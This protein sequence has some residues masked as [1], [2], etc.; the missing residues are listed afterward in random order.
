MTAAAPALDADLVAGLKRLKLATSGPSPPR[1]SRRPRPSAGRPKSVLRALVEAEIAARDDSNARTR[2]HAAGFP[3]A[4]T[5]EEFNVGAVVGPP[6]DLRLPGVPGVAPGGGEPLPGR[7]RRHRQEPPP[8]RPR[9]RRRLRRLQGPLLH[10]RRSGR[11]A[12]PRPGRQHRRPGHRRPAARRP[13]DRR[14]ARLRAARRIGTQLLFRFVAAAYERRSLGIAS[15]WPFDQWGRF[16]PEQTTAASLLDRLLHHAVI[17][18]TEG[19]SYRMRE[20][21]TEGRP[22]LDQG[23]MSHEPGGDF[24][25]PPAGT[26]RWPLTGTYPCR[27]QRRQKGANPR[28]RGPWR[29][30]GGMPESPVKRGMSPGCRERVRRSLVPA[31]SLRQPRL[32]D[33]A[34]SDLRAEREEAGRSA[35][36]PTSR[37]VSALQSGAGVRVANGGPEAAKRQLPRRARFDPGAPS[38]P[39]PGHPTALRAALRILAV[40]ALGATTSSVLPAPGLAA[41]SAR[42]RRRE[43]SKSSAAP[44]PDSLSGTEALSGGADGG[45]DAHNGS[46]TAN[47]AR[48]GTTSTTPAEAASGSTTTSSTTSST[49]TTTPS[50]APAAVTAQAPVEPQG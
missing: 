35:A 48:A 46:G 9:P 4:K 16:L 41:T 31:G 15:H 26:S 50:A 38:W 29:Q 45:A 5:L 42:E 24:R 22:P 34:R 6:G 37:D 33:N 20:A 2:L 3:V 44:K 12:L 32:R 47:D 40:L 8:G 23:L 1:S 28:L 7:P 10:R 43:T 39:A 19:E 18:V 17:V 11:D 14:R 25:W 13:R 49:T 36:N 27:S 30:D 21:K